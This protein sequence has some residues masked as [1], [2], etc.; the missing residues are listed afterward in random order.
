[1]LTFDSGQTLP[2]NRSV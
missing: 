1:M 2:V